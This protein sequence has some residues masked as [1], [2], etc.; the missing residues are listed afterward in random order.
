MTGVVDGDSKWNLSE[1]VILKNALTM[2]PA[3]DRDVLVGVEI[4]RVAS[5]GGNIAGEIKNKV[6]KYAVDDTTF[7]QFRIMR[8]ANLAFI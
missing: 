5:L 6:G 1:L 2:L 4:K 3:K 7:E 8:L